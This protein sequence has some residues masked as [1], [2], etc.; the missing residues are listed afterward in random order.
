M[1]HLEDKYNYLETIKQ[2]AEINAFVDLILYDKIYTPSGEQLQNTAGSI[3]LALIDC[4]RRNDKSMAAELFNHFAK[5]NPTK[6]SHWI[7]DEFVVFALISSVQKFSFDH[8][9]LKD[10]L[11]LASQTTDPVLQKVIETFKNILSSN[12]NVKGDF[13][14]ISLVYQ[15][16]SN[17]EQYDNERINK[18]FRD[19]WMLK[20]PFYDS[21]FL[22]IVSLK[23][24]QIAFEAKGLLDPQQYF[25]SKTFVDRFQ[26][27]SRIIG[28]L[29]SVLFLI[30]LA[31]FLALALWKASIINEKLTSFITSVAGVGITGVF[32]LHKRLKNF[33]SNLLRRIFGYKIIKETNAH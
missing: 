21:T 25:E 15:H 32:V 6:D 24:I 8:S 33:F 11:L 23:A 30:L 4:I 16:I 20:F 9:W 29:L 2:S 27:R 22:N 13:H 10:V 3:S 26:K 17:S 19:L 7:Y 31:L 1:V 14:Q 12:F 18:M 5:R 28:A